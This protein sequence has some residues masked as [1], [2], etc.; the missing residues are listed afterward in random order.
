MSQDPYRLPDN[1]VPSRY[2]LVLEPDLAAGTFVGTVATEL[3]VRARSEELVCNALDLEID[4]SWVEPEGGGRVECNARFEAE[5]ERVHLAL[6]TPIEPGSATLH[7]RF[8][9]ELNDK[10]VGFY[11]STFADDAGIEHTMA[12]T[13]FEATH[14]RRAFPCWDEPERKATLALTLVIDDA[15]VAVANGGVAREEPAGEGRRRITFTETM[16][17]STYVY[18]WVIGPLE[19]TGEVAAGGTMLRV[20]H[21]KGKGALTAFALESGKFGLEWLTTYYGIAYPGDKCDLVAVPDFAFGAMENLGCITFREALLLVDPER[22]TQPEL[23]RVA[24]VIHHELAHMWFGDLVTMRWWNGIWL[25]EAF[26]TFMEMKCTDAFRPAWDRWTDFGL[27]RTAAFDVDSL[28]STRAIEFDVVSP[29]EAEGMFDLLTYEKGAGVVRML[30]QYLGEER[31]RDGIRKYLADN[32]YANTETTDL[33]DALETATSE[34]VRHI[35]DTWIF[36]GGYPILDVEVGAGGTTLRLRQTRFSFD[37]GD[38]ATATH[39]ATWAVPVLMRYGAGDRVEDQRVLLDLPQDDFEL[40]FEPE[41]MQLNVGGSGFYRVRYTQ[42]QVSALG[43]RLD[44][45]SPL[46]RYQLV[47]DTFAAVLAGTTTA[48]EFLDLARRFVNDDDVSVWQRIAGGLAM[49]NRLIGDEARPRFQAT[50][51]ALAAPALARMG[52][53]PAPGESDRTRSLR[54][55]LFEL[56]G[57][58]G[59]DDS[60]LERARVL[61]AEFVADPESVDPELVA[62]A[63]GVIAERG[64]PD[65]FAAFASRMRT[66]D[67][68]QEELRYLYALP[69]FSDPSLFSA[70]LELAITEVRTQDAPF[71]LARALMNRTLGASAWEFVR[72]HWDELNERFPSSTIVRML[73]GVKVLIEPTVAADVVAFFAEHEVPQGKKTLEQQLE[74]L[75]VNVALREREAARLT[76]SLEA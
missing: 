40:N 32:A 21:P 3:A 20:A 1:A 72:G 22:A 5:T 33:W 71:L 68:P 49:L 54:A 57:T 26:A 41:W 23:Q 69:R 14:A 35:A 17:M 2:Q 30:E 51:R 44:R 76:A 47:D 29:E 19:L 10:L 55:A 13:Q 62:A 8:R 63:V 9:G 60:V 34:P 46:E 24:D 38:A 39:D 66:S 4:E 74:R 65:D 36:Q 43:Q 64:G 48:A 11:R 75:R 73:E 15:L 59:D 70:A 58:T 31:F 6:A 16:S 52:D 12:V 56:L 7:V 45:F 27:A 37:D 42:E 50:V 61:H 18:A 25:N 67:N 53:R 28:L